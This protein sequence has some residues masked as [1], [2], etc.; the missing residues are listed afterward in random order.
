MKTLTILLLALFLAAPGFAAENPSTCASWNRYHE[1]SKTQF[2]H[3]WL[4]GAEAADNLTPDVIMSN[5]WP[6]D[7]RVGS[8]VIEMD[9][10]CEKPTSRNGSLSQTMIRI[11]KRLNGVSP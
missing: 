2:V 9:V 1:N 4:R 3:G 6:T 10:E 7:H 5:L 11:A 8:V